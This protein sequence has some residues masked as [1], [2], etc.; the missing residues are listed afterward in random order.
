MLRSRRRVRKIMRFTGA[1][2]NC[3]L[4]PPVAVSFLPV[5]ST[6]P[7]TLDFSLSGK[8]P[9]LIRTREGGLLL[10]FPYTRAITWHLLKRYDML[11]CAA[12]II[13]DSPC[14]DLCHSP[15]GNDREVATLS[16]KVS[17]ETPVIRRRRGSARIDEDPPRHGKLTRRLTQACSHYLARWKNSRR[18]GAALGE[19]QRGLP[20]CRKYR[21]SRRALLEWH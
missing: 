2:V 9:I 5:V 4:P 10:P 19:A 15:H 16:F 17:R 12:A 14:R 21:T 8:L 18:P 1:S 11:Y 20:L 7:A 6:R 3:P 13:P